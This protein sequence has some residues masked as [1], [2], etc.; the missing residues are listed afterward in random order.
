MGTRGTFIGENPDNARDHRG[1][2]RFCNLASHART[3][4][5]PN[6]RTA[7]SPTWFASQGA[8]VDVVRSLPWKLVRIPKERTPAGPRGA[9]GGNTRKPM[10]SQGI[11]G[12]DE[13]ASNVPRGTFRCH[14]RISW[15]PRTPPR[16]PPGSHGSSHGVPH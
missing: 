7:A 14:G 16:K 12:P 13:V 2:G 9:S 1:T 3:R 10:R 5:Q 15:H 8:S 6:D 4:G 11:P